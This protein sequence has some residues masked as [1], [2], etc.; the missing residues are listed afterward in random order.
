MNTVSGMLFFVAN[1]GQYTQN[2]LFF[3]KVTFI[4][5]AG[6]Q[7][8]YL[9]VSD[10][11]W[12]LESGDDAGADSESRCRSGIVLV[13][14]CAVLGYCAPVP[15]LLVWDGCWPRTSTDPAIRLSIRV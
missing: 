6:L 10:R 11:A 13:V 5:L 9:T 2:P 12:V 4:L 8:F 1:P 15:A 14:Q 3:W 7:A